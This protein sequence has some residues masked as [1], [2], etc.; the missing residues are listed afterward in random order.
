MGNPTREDFM[1]L[2][3]IS[4]AAGASAIALAGALLAGP[5]AAAGQVT[6]RMHTHVPPVAQSFKNLTTWTKMVEKSSGG[7]LKI[8]LFGSNQLG[9]KAEDLFDQVKNGVVDIGWTLPGY[10][11]G[12]FPAV[13]VFELPFIGATADIA[14][15]AVDAFVRKYTK[16]F[17]DVHVIVVHSAGESVIHMKGDPIRRLED[18]RGKKIRTPSR[19]SSAALTALG[20]TPVPIPGLKMTEAL[21]R[22]VVDGAVTPWSIARAIRTVDVVESHTL[23]LLHG[24]VLAM[25]MNKQ[26]YAK[27]SA[28]AKKAIDD[29]SGEGVARMFGKM[30]VR[31]DIP[32]RKKAEELKHEIIEVSEQEQARWRKA[33]QPVYDDWIKTM[34]AKGFPAAQMVKD[35]EALIAKYKA[36]AK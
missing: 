25:L 5:A 14:S 30:W 28:A 22:N 13:T 1:G 33:T 23:T 21:M 10:K 11:A 36:E 12:L 8:Q 3:S 2:R 15:P 9:G 26:S 32:G 4:L 7:A 16:D 18:F 24:P 20:A 17:E 35:A 29:N 31:D 6:L 34:N 27:L 19:I